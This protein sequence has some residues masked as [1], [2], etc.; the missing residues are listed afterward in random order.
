MRRVRQTSGQL[1]PLAPLVAQTL[2]QAGLGSVAWLGRLVQRWEDIVGPQL[3]GVT[4]PDRLRSRVLFVTVS[5][6]IW[7]QQLMFYQSQLLQNIRQVFGDIPVRRLHFVL[8][9]ASPQPVQ[10]AV[11]QVPEPLPLT[12]TEEQ[13]MMD[14]TCGIADPELRESIRRAWRQGWQ[15]GR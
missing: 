14:D 4:R 11:A 5:D 13:R 10:P 6:T 12:A 7:M 8:A 2:Q 3:A 9:V 1:Q 15:A